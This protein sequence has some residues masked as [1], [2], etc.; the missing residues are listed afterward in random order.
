M[1]RVITYTEASKMYDDELIEVNYALDLYIDM[2]NKS[3]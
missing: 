1:E 2:I 3:S